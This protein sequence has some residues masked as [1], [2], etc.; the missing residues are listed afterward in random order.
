MVL[1]NV[2]KISS[3]LFLS[4]GNL[5]PKNQVIFEDKTYAEICSIDSAPEMKEIENNVFNDLGGG[6]AAGAAAG[7]TIGMVTRWR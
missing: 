5:K 2:S 6:T 1:I 7:A 3:E 4:E